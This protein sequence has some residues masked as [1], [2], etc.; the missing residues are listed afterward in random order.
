MSASRVPL[1]R[2]M[3]GTVQENAFSFDYSA[4]MLRVVQAELEID[5]VVQAGMNNV[6]NLQS[7]CDIKWSSR[8]NAL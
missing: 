8:A 1:V 5:V 7:H 6:T 4:N 2:N 3:M